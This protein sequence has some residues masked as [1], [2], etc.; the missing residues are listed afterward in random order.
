MA[1]AVQALRARIAEAFPGAAWVVFGHLA[2][3]NVHVNVMAEPTNP[4]ARKTAEAVVYGDV[5]DFGGSVSPEHGIGRMK[6]PYLH[7]SR[8]APELD[9]MAEIKAMLDPKGILSPGRVF[10]APE[11]P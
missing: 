7:R 6:A 1:A 5:S 9:L 2:D 8:S 3:A 4:A 11:T 10:E